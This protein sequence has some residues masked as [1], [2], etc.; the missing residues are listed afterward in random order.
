MLRIVVGGRGLGPTLGDAHQRRPQHPLAD[1]VAGLHHLRDGAGGLR[2]IRQLVHRLMQVG[3]ELVAL[4]RLEL[5]DAVLVEHLQEFALG[6]LDAVEQR[7]DAGVRGL[8]QFAVERL[9]R[10]FHVVGDRQH[11]ARERRD[12]VLAHVRDLAVGALAQVLHLRQRAQQ[13]VL[14]VGVLA[15]ER[16]HQRGDL[17]LLGRASA[18]SASLSLGFGGRILGAAYGVVRHRLCPFRNCVCSP[19][20]SGLGA[21]KSS[22]VG[23][24]RRHQAPISL[25]TTLAV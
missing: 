8:A 19:R 15:R 14:V 25:L 17:D 20:I 24:N 23:S 13:P 21:E 16:L 1:H 11:V 5:L 22:S 2:R 3:V 7:L 9:E 6:Q 4:L 18:P 12:A 10:A